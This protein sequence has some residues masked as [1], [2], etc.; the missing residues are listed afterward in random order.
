MSKE[1]LF[2]AIVA[3]GVAAG[4]GDERTE[5]AIAALRAEVKLATDKELDEVL[6]P[7]GPSLE[8]SA[9]FGSALIQMLK[10]AKE[11]WRAMK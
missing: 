11:F 5:A 2:K 8:A 7:E 1:S 6:G 10:L 9:K 4:V 3:A